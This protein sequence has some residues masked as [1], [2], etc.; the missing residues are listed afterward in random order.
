M[1]TARV[2]FF[3]TH[4]T[5]DLDKVADEL[6]LIDNGQI[7]FNKNKNTLVE[8]NKI[9]KGDSRFLNDK[10]IKLFKS[11]QITGFSFRGLTCNINAVRSDIK[12]IVIETPTIEDIMLGYIEINN[13]K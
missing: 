4:I 10:N 7:I 2:F 3:S 8:E 13:Q 12:D 9:V 5:S 11:M 1:I 6:I